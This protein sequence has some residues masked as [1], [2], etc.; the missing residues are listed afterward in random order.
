MT[1]PVYGREPVFKTRGGGYKPHF[2]IYIFSLSFFLFPVGQN[3]KPLGNAGYS[4]LAVS[5]TY[6]IHNTHIHMALGS[7]IAG[8]QMSENIH[9]L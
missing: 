4:P 6:T 7:H 9:L 1:Q 3:R 5:V 2:E 8:F